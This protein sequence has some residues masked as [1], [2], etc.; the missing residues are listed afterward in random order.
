MK[1]SSLLLPAIPS[2]AAAASL[3][4]YL[5][6]SSNSRTEAQT[7]IHESLKLT[8]S[9][10]DA[11]VLQRLG[12]DDLD[13]LRGT[14]EDD[15]VAWINQLGKPIKPLFED[16][17]ETKEPYQLVVALKGAS[18]KT[19]AA[20]RK[21]SRSH[22]SFTTSETKYLPSVYLPESLIMSSRGSQCKLLGAVK[23]GDKACWNGRSGYFEVEPEN[24][25]SWAFI[26]AEAYQSK[27]CINANIS[28]K[29]SDISR[30]INTIQALAASNKMETVLMAVPASASLSSRSEYN[31][32]RR[33]LDTT[34]EQVINEDDK[35]KSEH[36]DSSR[37]STSD[38][39][40]FATRPKGRVPAVFASRN[41]CETTTDFCS[42]HGR[43][44]NKFSSTSKNQ[45]WS[46]RCNSTYE[47]DHGGKS[48][49]MYNW[50]GNACE[51][52]DI[53]IPFWLILGFTVTIIGVVGASISLLFSVGE[54]KLPGVIGAGVSRGK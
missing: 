33:A 45:A 14:S 53:S 6:S 49:T 26:A 28:S 12:V 30:I 32:Q 54:E 39:H 31:K 36:V 44:F 25:G 5:F 23:P 51:K 41:A 15:V 9:G 52:I 20:L 1:L 50:G 7:H 29:Q 2:L 11:V 16:V 17:E 43:C 19:L 34:Q 37:P 40:N 47:S 42:G 4:A 13:G 22:S 8:A 3:E 18:D 21:L 35:P 46:C 10:A 38:F 27:I 24:V 48:N